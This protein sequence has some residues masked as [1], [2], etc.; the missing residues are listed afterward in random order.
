MADFRAGVTQVACNTRRRCC[1]LRCVSPPAHTDS[2][3]LFFKRVF[4]FVQSQNPSADFQNDLAAFRG[5]IRLTN[6]IA[7]ACRLLNAATDS[8]TTTVKGFGIR[9]TANYPRAFVLAYRRKTDGKTGDW[10]TATTRLIGKA[11]TKRDVRSTMNSDTHERETTAEV[12]QGQDRG[13]ST[14]R[15]YPEPSLQCSRRALPRGTS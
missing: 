15:S 5:A 4:P 13:V 3:A 12:A 14:V 9:I 1:L 7:R 11:N 2:P 6:T 10:T 8:S